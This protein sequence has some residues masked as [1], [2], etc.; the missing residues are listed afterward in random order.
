M[1]T[2]QSNPVAGAEPRTGRRPNPTIDGP[3]DQTVCFM[4][5]RG[6]KVAVDRLAYCVNITRS[7]LLSKIAA[8]FVEAAKGGRDGAKAQA[9]LLAYL[10]ECQ[11]SLKKRGE[12]AAK[13]ILP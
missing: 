11:K 7:G 13:W 5:S 9:Q 2:T 8:D 3:R 10:D 12:E 4:L 6:E 1:T